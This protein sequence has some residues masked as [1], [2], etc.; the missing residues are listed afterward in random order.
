MFWLTITALAAEPLLDHMDGHFAAATD[1]MSDV[2]TG[3]FER[4]RMEVSRLDHEPPDAL[5]EELHAYVA[6]VRSAAR[7]VAASP[8]MQEIADAVG[9]L[10]TACAA[11]HKAAGG[12]ARRAPRFDRDISEY[13]EQRRHMWTLNWLWYGLVVPDDGAWEAGANLAALPPA[14][15]RRAGAQ[16]LVRA[17][18]TA[19]RDAGEAKTDAERAS[20]FGA[21]LATCAAC[22]EATGVSL[23]P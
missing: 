15:Y 8:N 16:R 18:E 14:R 10:G 7:A 5:G 22:H 21:I 3:E 6:G 9:Q 11:C 12:G 23:S 19:A 17:Y 2:S 13:S 20:T 4:A 1:T